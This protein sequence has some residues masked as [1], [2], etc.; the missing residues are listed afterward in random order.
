MF[1]YRLH[2]VPTHPTD[3][4]FRTKGAGTALVILT[5]ILAAGYT[6]VATMILSPHPEWLGAC[7]VFAILAFFTLMWLLVLTGYRR[8]RQPSNWLLRFDGTRL[9]IKFRSYL[10]SHFSDGDPQAF[11]LEPEEIAWIREYRETR[12]TLDSDRALT[13]ESIISLDIALHGMETN[14]LEAL[15]LAESARPAPMQGRFIKSSTKYG[16]MQ[17][18]LIDKRILRL[19][20]S[21]RTGRVYPRIRDALRIVGSRFPVQATLKETNNFTKTDQLTDAEKDCHIQELITVGDHMAAI[22]LTR[23]LY[24]LSLTDATKKV[25]SLSS[26]DSASAPITA[27]KPS[28]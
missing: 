13:K 8:S 27:Q 19:L 15:L 17:V 9:I 7:F 25:E 1:I 12:I 3:T 4:V 26:L 16:G 2:E 10:N 21:D 22:A 6:F 28:T 11:S 18:Q 14:V 5:I 24:K 23:K 20:W